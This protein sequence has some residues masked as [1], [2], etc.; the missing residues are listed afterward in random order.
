MAAGFQVS[1]LIQPR[2]KSTRFQGFVGQVRELAPDLLMCTVR[3]CR[4]IAAAIPSSGPSSIMKV[5]PA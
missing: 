5:K 3:H 1:F 4:N 2:R